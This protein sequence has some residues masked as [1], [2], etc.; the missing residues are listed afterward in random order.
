MSYKNFT[1]ETVSQQL[2][3]TLE[4][5]QDLFSATNGQVPLANAFTS[6]LNYRLT[7]PEGSN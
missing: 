1:L 4:S 3:L 6:Y 2:G 5:N 7:V